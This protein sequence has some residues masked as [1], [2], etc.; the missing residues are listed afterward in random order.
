M[1]RSLV[2]LAALLLLL[3]SYAKASRQIF[4]LPEPQ[5]VI[6]PVTQ[7]PTDVQYKPIVTV[8]PHWEVLSPEEV[9]QK[10]LGAVVK[11]RMFKTITIPGT[12]QR[13]YLDAHAWGSGSV[14]PCK[15]HT[16][17][18]VLTAFHVVSDSSMTYFAHFDDGSPDQMLTVVYGT[19]TYDNAVLRFADPNFVPK[20]VAVLGSSAPLVPGTPIYAIGSPV[21]GDFHYSVGRL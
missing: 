17:Y 8:S 9:Y 18:C 7:H 6:V 11:V 10:N 15:K 1:K 13:I 3:F 14:L 2:V 4:I 5:F 16:A 20:Y 21:Y 19:T 12:H